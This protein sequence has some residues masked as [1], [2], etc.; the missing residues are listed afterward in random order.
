[1]VR[2]AFV[3][4]RGMVG[5]VLMDR[6]LAENDFKGFEATFF[7]TSQVGGKGLQVGMDIPPLKDAYDI[8]ALA[9]ADIVVTCRAATIPR[10]STPRSA[11]RAG[12]ATGW[13]LP[14][15]CACRQTASSY[16][17]RSTGK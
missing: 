2:V 3:G 15:P 6:M 13:T 1:M 7:T 14:R 8:K 9:D 11:P 12:K 5:S 4:W 16:W 17:T 10:R